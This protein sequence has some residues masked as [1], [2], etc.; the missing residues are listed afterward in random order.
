MELC[1]GIFKIF[2]TIFKLNRVGCTIGQAVATREQNSLW[3]N[4]LCFM[5]RY[6]DPNLDLDPDPNLHLA[7]QPWPPGKKCAPPMCLKNC[8]EK[9]WE[10][11]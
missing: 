3:K 1:K 7:A 8:C 10:S 9:G 5:L 6:L 4:F 11:L 2:L